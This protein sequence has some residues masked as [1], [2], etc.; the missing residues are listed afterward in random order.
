MN[1][2]DAK[3]FL[4]EAHSICNLA[5]ASCRKLYS[6]L[7]KIFVPVILLLLFNIKASS[8][9]ENASQACSRIVEHGT[10]VAAIGFICSTVYTIRHAYFTRIYGLK[11]RSPRRRVYFV[12]FHSSI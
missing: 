3:H 4:K 8:R 2:F 10:V 12:I 5:V 11:F 1:D 9:S 7:N 6:S